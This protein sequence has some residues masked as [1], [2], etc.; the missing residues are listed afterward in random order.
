M[1]WASRSRSAARYQELP[2]A[3][4]WSKYRD[5]PGAAANAEAWQILSPVRAGLGGVD[6]LNRMTQSRLRW[7]GLRAGSPGGQ[8]A[9]RRRLMLSRPGSLSDHSRRHAARGNL[10]IAL[11][12]AQGL[13]AAESERAATPR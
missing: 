12:K 7:T 13:R 11:R 4:F 6:A 5:N 9:P 10:L 1:S 8:L 3:F 2:W